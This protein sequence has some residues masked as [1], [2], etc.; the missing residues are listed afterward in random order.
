MSDETKKLIEDLKAIRLEL[1]RSAANL[2]DT[3]A[4]LETGIHKEMDAD[5]IR[6]MV[7]AVCNWR[8]TAR[9]F[10]DWK[11]L[12]ELENETWLKLIDSVK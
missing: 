10:R 4:Q 7:Y 11:K 2:D 6:T 1:F 8:R 3:I 9:D 12:D 5:S